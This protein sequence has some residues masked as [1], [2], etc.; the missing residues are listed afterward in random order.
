MMAAWMVL[1][2]ALRRDLWKAAQSEV[3]L[4]VLRAAG[5][6]SMMGRKWERKRVVQLDLREAALMVEMMAARREP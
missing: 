3:N 5:K 4:A 6:A 2:S 1:K